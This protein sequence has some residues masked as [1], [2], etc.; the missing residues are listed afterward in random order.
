MV[1]VPIW[2]PIAGV[3]TLIGSAFGALYPG[4]SAARHDTIEALSYE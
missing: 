2:W 4:L 3:V 1:I